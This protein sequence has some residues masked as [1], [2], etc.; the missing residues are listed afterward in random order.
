M[1]KRPKP[2]DEIEARPWRDYVPKPVEGSREPVMAP[3]GW[4][5]LLLAIIVIAAYHFTAT[6]FHG[7]IDPWV[8]RLF[9]TG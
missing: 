5:A 2:P 9:G 3:G 1:P 6:W 8:D 4:W 7:I